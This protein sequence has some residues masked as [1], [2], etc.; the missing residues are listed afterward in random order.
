VAARYALEH[1]YYGQVVKDG[2]PAGE[3]RLLAASK[4]VNLTQLPDIV[5][6]ASLPPLGDVPLGSWGIVHG[7]NGTF[8]FVQSQINSAGAA[9]LHLAAAPPELMR[10]LG[11]NIRLLAGLLQS[12]MPVYEKPGATLPPLSMPIVQ[13]PDEASQADAMLMLMTCAQNRLG[14]IESL[15]AALIHGVQLV[16]LNAP[17]DPFKRTA[18]IEG[19]LAL[20]P[21]SARFGV[22]FALHTVDSTRVDTQ[23]RYLADAE[24]PEGA[25]LFHWPDAK[26]TGRVVSD[27]YSR[28]MVSQLRLDTSLV[29]EQTNAMTPVAAW[30]ISCGE[31]LA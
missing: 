25:A 12:A 11:G 18:L 9:M 4:G 28:F 2:T 29:L 27:N 21:S 15:L 8:Y 7:F 17:P 1:F 10:A 30:R 22:T 20:L 16:I 19:L 26:V 14:V 6:V 3:P 13:P 31:T 24:P 5:G 23:I